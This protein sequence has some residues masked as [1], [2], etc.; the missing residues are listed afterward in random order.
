[1]ADTSFLKVAHPI[2]LWLELA[3]DFASGDQANVA[4][5]GATL[6]SPKNYDIKGSNAL[7]S[8]EIHR[9]CLYLTNGN[10][11]PTTFGG[12]DE[13]PNG[14]LVKLL[15]S[16]NAVVVDFLDGQSIKTDADWSMLVGATDYRYVRAIP[17]NTDDLFHVTW[18]I[19]HFTGGKPLS[20]SGGHKIR[21][22]VQDELDDITLIRVMGQGVT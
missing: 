8:I 5:A 19:T 15:D 16:N 2:E 22:T 18:D 13:L 17:G 21:F 7:D 20:L 6:G 14:V 4:T 9:V 10:L 3:K 1:M 11:N 12:I